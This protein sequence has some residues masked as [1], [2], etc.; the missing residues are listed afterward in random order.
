MALNLEV[1]QRVNNGHFGHFFRKAHLGQPELSRITRKQHKCNPKTDIYVT[2]DG[3]RCLFIRVSGPVFKII[4]DFLRM[5]QKA[6]QTRFEPKVRIC[7]KLTKGIGLKPLSGFW[8]LA[9]YWISWNYGRIWVLSVRLSLRNNELIPGNP[10]F[11]QKSTSKDA[12]T[13]LACSRPQRSQNDT[14]CARAGCTH[15]CPVSH[16]RTRARAGPGGSTLK[17]C[18]GCH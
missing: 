7:L 2:F 6:K 12:L 17:V 11:P 16:A 14:L 15:R 10:A 3:F 1:S 9:E 4:P 8:V 18:L 5:C 13:F